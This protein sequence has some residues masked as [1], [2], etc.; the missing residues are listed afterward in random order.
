MNQTIKFKQPVPFFQIRNAIKKVIDEYLPTGDLDEFSRIIWKHNMDEF[1]KD[2]SSVFISND[3]KVFRNRKFPMYRDYDYSDLHTQDFVLIDA[4]LPG[5][6]LLCDDGMHGHNIVKHFS[7]DD[8]FTGIQYR[9]SETY[10]F[11][12]EE[13]EEWFGRLKGIITFI[14][15]ELEQ[16]PKK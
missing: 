5:R 13:K 10:E 3:L 1:Y 6:I 15:N 8:V 16:T 9:L 11:T 7:K 12:D 14:L 2:S 4:G